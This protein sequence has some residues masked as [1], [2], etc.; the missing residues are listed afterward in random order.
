MIALRSGGFDVNAKDQEGKTGL[1]GAC[2][3]GSTNMIRILLEYPETDVNARDPQ[4]NT[5]LM[6]TCAYGL[7]D[8]VIELMSHEKID[9]EVQNEN[10]HTALMEAASGGYVDIVNYLV[11][12]GSNISIHSNEYKETALT[13]AAYKGHLEVVRVLIAAITNYE[14]IPEELHTAL[15]E[16]SMDGHVDVAQLLIDKGAMVN[17][18]PDNF[19]SPLTL[20]ACGGHVELAMLLL[21]RGA[22]LE[23]VN[24]EGYNALMEASREGH[25]EMV[26]LLLTQGAKPNVL[27]EESKETA[28]CMAASVGNLEVVKLLLLKGADV[29]LGASTPLME[30]SAEGHVDIVALLLR[31]NA[32]INLVNSQGDTALSLACDIGNLEVVKLLLSYKAD[33]NHGNKEGRTPLMKAA[34]NGHLD[35]VSMLVHSGARVNQTTHCNDHTALSLACTTGHKQVVELLLLSGAD[36]KHRLKDNSAM[37]LEAARC[38]HKEIVQMLLDW[39]KCHSSCEPVQPPNLHAKGELLPS[40]KQLPPEQHPAA[41]KKLPPVKVSPKQKNSK[42]QKNTKSKPN[43]PKPAVEEAAVITNCKGVGNLQNGKLVPSG[44]A[45]DYL[46]GRELSSLPYSCQNVDELVDDV[47]EEDVDGEEIDYDDIEDEVTNDPKELAKKE[48]TSKNMTRLVRLKKAQHDE[49]TRLM[50]RQ[51]Q[52]SARMARISQNSLFAPMS[53]VFF[54]KLTEL[55]NQKRTARKATAEDG[56]KDATASSIWLTDFAKRI[57]K[58]NAKKEKG[59]PKEL[60]FPTDEATLKKIAVI[61]ALPQSPRD[62]ILNSRNGNSP[63][64]YISNHIVSS[65]FCILFRYYFMPNVRQTMLSDDTILDDLYSEMF[66]MIKNQILKSSQVDWLKDRFQ[67]IKELSQKRFYDFENMT[68]DD[69]N[70]LVD[71]TMM[72]AFRSKVNVEDYDLIVPGY[73][74]FKYLTVYDLKLPHPMPPTKLGALGEHFSKVVHFRSHCNVINN[75][76][77]I[78]LPVVELFR[79]PEPPSEEDNLDTLWPLYSRAYMMK[80]PIYKTVVK[81]VDGPQDLSQQKGNPSI[82]GSSSTI[83]NEQAV[84]EQ[85]AVPPTAATETVANAANPVVGSVADDPDAAETKIRPEKRKRIIGY[86]YSEM[87]LPIN[88]NQL[89]FGMVGNQMVPLTYLNDTLFEIFKKMALSFFFANQAD[90]NHNL[91]LMPPELRKLIV[92]PDINLATVAKNNMYMNDDELSMTSS[93][94]D[95]SLL[96]S[97]EQQNIGDNLAEFVAESEAPNN[98]EV[99]VGEADEAETL[100]KKPAST[101]PKNFDLSDSITR[102]SFC[103]AFPELAH[104]RQDELQLGPSQSTS[105]TTDKK[106]IAPLKPLDLSDRYDENNVKMQHLANEIFKV[107]EKKGGS[108]LVP[109]SNIQSIAM[110]LQSFAA[111]P[112]H[113]LPYVKPNEMEMIFD[114]LNLP[115]PGSEEFSPCDEV[116]YFPSNVAD[117]V[118]SGDDEDYEYEEDEE[119]EDGGGGGEVAEEGEGN[120]HQEEQ[121]ADSDPAAA[122]DQSSRKRKSEVASASLPERRPEDEMTKYNH[123][124]EEELRNELLKEK[125][126]LEGKCLGNCVKV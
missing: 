124:T 73:V 70:S 2:L 112:R 59:G 126:I 62:Y 105:T 57:V 71:H 11:S 117:V 39:D 44:P 69:E 10:G 111:Q 85:Q 38:G 55:K 96:M 19:E 83:T 87:Q 106:E 15:M 9:L 97:S 3:L 66:A 56:G 24:D 36:D 67:L 104:L 37:L 27:T 23:E 125:A 60:V 78:D 114:L 52:M 100:E 43:E 46:K 95:L 88:P 54:D 93:Q 25:E 32:K 119:E 47:K 5:A 50:C 115:M 72:K 84:L 65:I 90:L 80:R 16:A 103:R 120:E 107:A 77:N 116:E 28:L 35:T 121:T 89:I 41:V 34:Y 82:V 123:M 75:A 31:S 30:A 40:M 12:H 49:M 92:L 76:Q 102:E 118:L 26:A 94:E 74:L 79:G 42:P 21:K 64:I 7:L 63:Y 18:P 99:V 14:T 45:F 33:V 22:N 110:H 91:K 109:T 101:V 58:E 20:A 81:M 68:E 29:N 4:G 48:F 6:L 17:M 86:D 113:M 1:M 13:L 122:A 51:A 61:Y 108:L 53:S 8:P 98:A